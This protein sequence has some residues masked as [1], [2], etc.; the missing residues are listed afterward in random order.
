MISQLYADEKVF[1]ILAYSIEEEGISIGIGDTLLVGGDLDPEKAIIMKPDIFY[2]SK[3]MKGN[4]PKSAD[5]VVFVDDSGDYHLYVAE[6]KSSRLPAIKKSDIKEKFDT[7]FERF[8]V[9]DYAHVFDNQQMPYNLVSLNI[10]LVCDP[11]RLREKSTDH[12]DFIR[13]AAALKSKMRTL[14]ADYASSFKP[15]AFKGIVATVQPMLSPPT[16]EVGGFTDL[17][18]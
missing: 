6:L 10:W 8:F 12:D 11:L 14:L 18:A 2:S 5:G 15:Y 7:I 4:T 3:N 16:I 17:L 13:R 9:D 1:E